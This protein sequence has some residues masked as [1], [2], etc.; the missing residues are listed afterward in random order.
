MKELESNLKSE[1]QELEVVQKK[2]QEIEYK[3]V[4]E[5]KPKKGHTL[6]EINLA[7]MKVREAEKTTFSTITWEQAIKLMNGQNLDK[8][9]VKANHVYIS[10]LNKESALNRYLSGKGSCEMSKGIGIDID[11][12][13]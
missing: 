13:N 7:N 10:A 1:K 4:G 6:F 3:K 5:L 12:I 2:A 11:F 9:L 8:V